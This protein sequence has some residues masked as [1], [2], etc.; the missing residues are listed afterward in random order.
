M[1]GGCSQK[2]Y[3]RSWV[4]GGDRGKEKRSQNSAEQFWRSLW[5]PEIIPKRQKT[6]FLLYL[7]GCLWETRANPP[8]PPSLPIG[9]REILRLLNEL[10]DLLQ[11]P[12]ATL[13]PHTQHRVGRLHISAM[14]FPMEAR[15][16]PAVVIA[17][18][19]DLERAMQ[20]FPKHDI[21]CRMC[22]CCVSV[23]RRLPNEIHVSVEST[24]K[25]QWREIQ[26]RNEECSGRN[27]ILGVR[28]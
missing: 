25:E 27:N 23:E 28:G 2:C 6:Q 12:Q 3:R 13:R 22:V 18:V 9:R 20:E 19:R 14:V 8:S 5:A 15:V 1:I 17:V 26:G 4:L 7:L 11:I 16:T 24:A 21:L 10:T